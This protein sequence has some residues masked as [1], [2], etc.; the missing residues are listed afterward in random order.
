MSASVV[1]RGSGSIGQRHARVFR[2]VGADVALW[3]VRDRG[4]AAAGAVDEATGAH[5][6]D[7][8]T[9]PDAVRGATLVVVATDTSRH[10]T[11]ALEALDGGAEKVL[12]EKPVAPTAPEATALSEHLRH[13]LVWVAAPLRAHEGFRHLRRL[14]RH[15]EGPASAHVWSQSWLPD[16]RPDRDYRRSYSARPDEGGV[17][18]DLVHEIDYAGALFGAPTLLGAAVDTSGPLDIEAD[19]AATLLWSTDRSFT[20]TARL[21]YTT[22]PTSRGVVV[23]S[24][25]GSLEWDVVRA[26]VR[27]TTP[28]GDTTEQVFDHDLDR[29]IVMGTQ[30]RAALDLL[31]TAPADER[32]ARGAPASLAEGVAAVRLCDSARAA[33]HA[34]GDERTQK[35]PT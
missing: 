1:V 21:D 22:R 9:G 3:P 33:G 25:G 13:T 16:W 15:L 14:V 19:Q 29:D 23:H 32:I 20:V 11:D 10:V 18:R 28:E 27:H 12:L 30:A 34:S 35:E 31:P 17:L 4:P 26:V 7:D 8:T 24:P 2:Q 5:L 6:L